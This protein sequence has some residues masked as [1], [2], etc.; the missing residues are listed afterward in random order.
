MIFNFYE[1][2]RQRGIDDDAR[3]P[4]FFNRLFLFNQVTVAIFPGQPKIAAAGGYE[5]NGLEM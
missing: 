4:F 1:N 2:A 3:F 5:I